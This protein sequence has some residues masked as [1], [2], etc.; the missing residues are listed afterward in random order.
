[1]HTR[2]VG[3]SLTNMASGAMKKHRMHMMQDIRNHRKE[4]RGSSSAMQ[5][6]GMSGFARKGLS[7]YL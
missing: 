4:R 3:G 7:E 5:N 6:E 1:M 2:M